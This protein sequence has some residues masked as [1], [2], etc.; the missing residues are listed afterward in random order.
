[1]PS[2]FPVNPELT[3]IAIGY[4]NTDD[5]LIADQVLPRVPVAET[6]KWTQYDT[7]QAYTVPE[8]KVGRKSEPF[9]VD[10]Q[11]TDV[12]DTTDDYALDDFVPQKDIEVYD[13]MPKPATG[14]PLSPQ[15]LATMMLTN[16]VELAREVRVANTVFNAANYAAGQTET[17]AG[18][19]Q[20]SDYVNSDPLADLMAALDVPLLRPNT[21]T[22]GR[23]AWTV[24]RQHPKIV[25]AIF[26][27]VQGAGVVAQ[28]AVADLLEIKQVLVGSGRVNTAKKGQNP[29]YVRVW[30]KNAALIYVSEA[31][32]QT[33][34][35]TFGFTAQFGTK[36]AAN[37][38]DLKRGIK[39][40]ETIRVGE[41]VKE[42]VS[43]PAS[44]Y[45]IENAVA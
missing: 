1:M 40:G 44:G 21:L 41:Q 5:M 12:Q 20:W 27:T 35:P 33:F 43:A 24:L 6:F 45:F 15:A 13:A 39:G 26:K 10:F 8:T 18:T 34:Q 31:A 14:G 23:Q 3:A 42:I 37:I 29:N 7:D 28:Q 2:P 11:G 25:Q 36:I 17:L 32:A 38:P 19:S 30:G 16:L 22:I 4:K 9:T